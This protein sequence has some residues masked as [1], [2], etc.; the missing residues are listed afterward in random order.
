[1]RAGGRYRI[2][3][4]TPDGE[5]HEVCGEY[6]EVVPHEKLVFSWAWRSTPERVSLVTVTLRTCEGGT[7]LD[8][9]HQRFFDEQAR[10]GHLHGWTLTFAK[11][12]DWLAQGEARP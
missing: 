12:D 2:R 5:T 7:E 3:F 4:H 6:Q 9:L 1:V 10:A 8:F 11:L